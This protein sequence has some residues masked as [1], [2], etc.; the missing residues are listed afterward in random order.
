[1]CMSREPLA[2]C[3]LLLSCLGWHPLGHPGQWL[4]LAA[5]A[6]RKGAEGAG[7]GL[8]ADVAVST[9]ELRA[10]G[11]PAGIGAADVGTSS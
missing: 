4:G 11:A 3:C 8:A 9:D 7:R 6:V 1:M 10:L 2:A 5:V